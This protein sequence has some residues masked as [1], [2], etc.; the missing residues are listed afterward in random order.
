MP[1]LLPM[2]LTTT[3]WILYKAISLKGKKEPKLT[4]FTTLILTLY[5]VPQRSILRTLLFNIYIS[6]MFYDIDNCN[7]ASYADDNTSYTSDLILE[8]V[9]QKLD[10]ISNNLFEWF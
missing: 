2:V 9:I 7:I 10:L 6:D 3:F 5:G 4:T 1:N 8:E